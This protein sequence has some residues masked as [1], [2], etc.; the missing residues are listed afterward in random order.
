SFGVDLYDVREFSFNGTVV[1]HSKVSLTHWKINTK[2]TLES[3]TWNQSPSTVV[4]GKEIPITYLINPALKLFKPNIEKSIDQS[5]GKSMDFKSNVLDA[6]ALLC[7]PRQL[8]ESYQTWLRIVP[9][10]IYTTQAVLRDGV[11]SL[12][13]GFKGNVGT[14]I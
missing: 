2:T 10:E 4:M 5:I 8:S 13:M 3:L 9:T 6:V 12:D 1:L 7:E 11:I 14:F